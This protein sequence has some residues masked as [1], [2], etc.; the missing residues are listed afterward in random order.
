[1]NIH[2]ELCLFGCGAQAVARRWKAAQLLAHGSVEPT[3]KPKL[4]FN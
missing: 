4:L 1:M 3:S 2:I